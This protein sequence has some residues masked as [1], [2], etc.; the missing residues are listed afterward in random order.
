MPKS[1]QRDYILFIDCSLSRPR[2]SVWRPEL[3]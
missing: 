3:R 1:D 2:S